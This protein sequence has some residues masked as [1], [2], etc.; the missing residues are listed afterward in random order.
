MMMFI[1]AAVAAAQPA[2]SPAQQLATSDM[3]HMQHMRHEGMKSHCCKE[4]CRH[5]S[6]GHQDVDAANAQS[7]RSQ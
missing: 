7:Q 2:S 6:E 5:M 1:A 4:C 3:Q